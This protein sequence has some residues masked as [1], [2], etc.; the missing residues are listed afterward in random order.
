M[1][2]LSFLFFIFFASIC[3]GQQK[4]IALVI[5]N[6]SYKKNPLTNPINDAKLIAKTIKECGFEVT[7]LQDASKN[8]MLDAIY[9]FTDSL[10]LNKN[11]VGF[12]YFAGHGSQLN[13]QN[14]FWPIDA[15]IEKERE[16]D[17]KCI[18]TQKL[19]NAFGED[20]QNLLIAV[21]DACRNNP[22]ENSR[23]QGQGNGLAKINPASGMLV[24]YS[25]QPGNTAKDNE[26]QENSTYS[27]ALAE[28]LLIPNQDVE[29]IFKKV[30]TIV[31]DRSGFI[32]SP[33]E[34][35]ALRG[36]PFYFIKTA[37]AESLSI[38]HLIAD[39]PSSLDSAN[40]S[41]ALN[42]AS[43]IWNFYK[44]KY[45]LNGDEV[46]Y[47]KYTKTDVEALTK[48][49]M[50]LTISDYDAEFYHRKF[51]GSSKSV[52]VHF[53][54]MSHDILKEIANTLMSIHDIDF[55]GQGLVSPESYLICHLRLL[56][57]DYDI[58]TGPGIYNYSLSVQVFDDLIEY[59]KE[60]L[61]ANKQDYYLGVINYFYSRVL[62]E[63]GN[64]LGMQK[65]REAIRYLRNSSLS[66]A[67]SYKLTGAKGW[68]KSCETEF[69]SSNISFAKNYEAWLIGSEDDNWAKMFLDTLDYESHQLYFNDQ[70]SFLNDLYNEDRF[71]NDKSVFINSMTLFEVLTRNFS[72]Y[73]SEK[74]YE[75]LESFKAKLFDLSENK[76]SDLPSLD[77]HLN[78]INQGLYR[79]LTHNEKIDFSSE[80]LRASLYKAES[81]VTRFYNNCKYNNKSDID[82]LNNALYIIASLVG[83]YHSMQMKIPIDK[84]DKYLFPIDKAIQ[85]FEYYVPL[86][87]NMIHSLRS[88]KDIQNSGKILDG[89]FTSIHTLLNLP[90]EHKYDIDSLNLNISKLELDYYLTWRNGFVS[91]LELYVNY[92]SQLIKVGGEDKMSDALLVSKSCFELF[93]TYKN[94]WKNEGYNISEIEGAIWLSLF[95]EIP[96][97]YYPYWDQFTQS[98]IL[99]LKAQLF[100]QKQRILAISKISEDE[101][102]NRMPIELFERLMYLYLPI[103]T[104][105][106]LDFSSNSANLSIES[107]LF[108]VSKEMLL[109]H[110]QN[111]IEYKYYYEEK[112]SQVIW[113][114]YTYKDYIETLDT[115]TISE[116]ITILRGFT[117]YDPSNE[118]FQL[119]GLLASY[120]KS[121]KQAQEVNF[122]AA[123]VFLEYTQNKFWQPHVYYDYAVDFM[124]QGVNYK[125]TSNIQRQ[126]YIDL[127]IEYLN[128]LTPYLGQPEQI[129]EDS[130]SLNS[131]VVVEKIRLIEYNI[132]DSYYW[133]EDFKKCY[134]FYN[135]N[136]ATINLISNDSLRDFYR[137]QNYEEQ[138]WV[139]NRNLKRRKDANKINTDY[140]DFIFGIEVIDIS[141]YNCKKVDKKI[142]SYTIPFFQITFDLPDF[143]YPIIEFDV[144]ANGKID[145]TIDTRYFYN[146]QSNKINTEYIKTIDYDIIGGFYEDFEN[147]DGT[148]RQDTSS[149]IFIDKS[150]N[151]ESGIFWSVEPLSSPHPYSGLKFEGK[152][153]AKWT[154]EIPIEEITTNNNN[155]I[156][157]LVTPYT[158]SPP[159]FIHSKRH[160]KYI[161]PPSGRIYQFEQPFVF[162]FE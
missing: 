24:A 105:Y 73:I 12:F 133:M 116:L 61:E 1:K 103:A 62:T 156:H 50:S 98:D 20:N 124:G 142:G 36:D 111:D 21:L 25:T 147:R 101:E 46:D 96:P 83:S 110:I 59:A 91:G 117:V 97:S 69:L 135:K 32:Q 8:Q 29:T 162:S 88:S 23:G 94:S 150:P 129:I 141:H 49:M 153:I 47:S 77:E 3:F 5:G 63:R 128:Y 45:D 154:I 104:E 155:R 44:N 158:Q 107:E 99:M 121:E 15:V 106:N 75:N 127:N 80:I 35:S 52:N 123:R 79:S 65:S 54:A 13:G 53:I 115:A 143:F 34:E 134:E 10:Q 70:L 22:F 87:A 28:Q 37:E 56:N 66:H 126:E 72:P 42:D 102:I 144:N 120:Q 148:A 152:N 51:S 89:F 43:T 146:Y 17:D 60:N 18:S 78:K 76:W 64:L 71:V 108:D 114:E 11:N 30:R 151:F 19:F 139:L 48:I 113:S 9:S 160:E 95:Q 2:N 27:K 136:E 122:M 132:A 81:R 130:L 14:Y 159:G 92:A 58:F 138:I 55:N 40:I 100:L 149:L 90:V 137:A 119:Y 109:D 4:R 74:E 41:D 6:N 118:L 140:L 112:L 84:R 7:L 82:Q 31:E 161:F 57:N 131:Q 26:D 38:A 16:T 68:L 145:S 33:R 125:F 157:F 67:E 93:E 39:F 86:A 85:K